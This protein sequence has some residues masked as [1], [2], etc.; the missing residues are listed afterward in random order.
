MRSER[1]PANLEC[2]SDRQRRGLLSSD[3]NVAIVD[4]TQAAAAAGL[5]VAIG[6]AHHLHPP[7]SSSVYSIAMLSG[8][9]Y[10]RSFIHQQW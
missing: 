1:G 6:N 2:S 7:A 4:R 3:V 9:R 10:T 8:A 5:A